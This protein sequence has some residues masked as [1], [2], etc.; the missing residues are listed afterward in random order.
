PGQAGGL[1]KEFGFVLAFSVFLSSIVALTLCPM[2]ASR[3]LKEGRHG[4]A[5]PGPL[6][7]LGTGTQKL[8]SRTLRACLNAPLIVVLVAAVFAAAAFTMFVGVKNELT[9][10]EDRSMA[11]MRITAPQGVSL[12]YLSGKLQQ[13]EASFK[14]LI[15]SGELETTFS[16][17]G[18]GGTNSAFLVLGLAPWNQRD[19]SQQEILNEVNQLASQVAG[20][21][22]FAFQPNSLN[23]RGSGS[24]LQFA[25][26]GRRRARPTG[27]PP[28]ITADQ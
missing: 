12:D 18:Q 6:A 22:A 11:M 10:S 26:A 17:I 14:P 8:Y 13:I 1:F 21:R 27:A 4:K 23:I 24:G 16:V 2:L 19:R 28:A 5:T 7:R 9:P 3:F 25:V 20:V 15:D